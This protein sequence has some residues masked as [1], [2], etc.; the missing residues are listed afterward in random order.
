MKLEQLYKNLED[1]PSF[2][3]ESFIR[4]YMLQRL[5]DLKEITINIRSSVTKL[6]KVDISPAQVTAL[7]KL[8][9]GIGDLNQ[10]RKMSAKK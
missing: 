5:E 6:K 1:M 4:T 10:L 3:Q 2:E 7:K 8:G 9:I